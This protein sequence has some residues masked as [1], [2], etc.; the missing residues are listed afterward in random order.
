MSKDELLKSMWRD[1]RWRKKV[2]NSLLTA[3]MGLGDYASMEENKKTLPARGKV[4]PVTSNIIF[5]LR[6]GAKYIYD[7]KELL[8]D[9]LTSN[10]QVYYEIQE[11]RLV[12]IVPARKISAIVDELKNKV[13]REGFGATPPLR[14]L[15]MLR[16]IE[17]LVP[18]NKT[19]ATVREEMEQVLYNF[20]K[21]KTPKPKPASPPEPVKPAPMVQ[22]D[23]S[24]LEMAK[25][26]TTAKRHEEA[27]KY[28]LRAIALGNYPR[29]CINITANTYATLYKQARQSATEEQAEKLRQEAIA[30]MRKHSGELDDTT[31]TWYTLENYYYCMRD[32][33]DFFKV[34]AKLMRQNEVKNDPIKLSDYHNKMAAAYI[35]LKNYSEAKEAINKSLKVMPNNPGAMKLQGVIEELEKLNRALQTADEKEAREIQEKI[36]EISS[37][38]LSSFVEGGLGVFITRL[39]DEYTDME[40]LDAKTKLS[41][42]YTRSTIFNIRGFI[43][44]A[45][46]R[47]D[48][49][50]KL[51]LTEVKVIQALGFQE[52]GISVRG[53]M[54]QYCNTMA[55]LKL[56]NGNDL[57]VV[58]FFYNQAFM[59]G[60]NDR[61][62][63]YTSAYLQTLLYP[64]EE[65][66]RRIVNK[67]S[68][69]VNELLQ[70][71]LL[72]NE[73]SDRNWE[74]VLGLTLYNLVL[75]NQIVMKIYNNADLR[76]CCL[77]MMGHQNLNIDDCTT[78]EAFKSRWDQLR[79]RRL[80]E[81]SRLATQ[82]S[83]FGNDFS[84]LEEIN[85]NLRPELVRWRNES[86]LRNTMDSR[87]LGQILDNVL[88]S[89]SSFLSNRA[90]LIKENAYNNL[91]SQ[92]SKLIADIKENPTKLSYEALI[93]L[94]AKIQSLADNAFDII[95]KTSEPEIKINLLSATVAD[96]GVVSLQ[97]S[98]SNGVDSSPV[99]SVTVIIKNGNGVT[100]IDT[101]QKATVTI[102]GG[103]QHIFK[104][105]VKVSEEVIRKESVSL[106]ITCHY[107]DRKETKPKHVDYS[108]QLPL[109]S[110]EDFKPITNNPYRPGDALAIDDDTF[111]GRELF[112][113]E[114]INDI[115]NRGD[116]QQGYQ[117]IIFGQK[118][119]GKT[120]VWER[121]ASRLQ[122]D[123]YFCVKFS[124]QEILR[125]VTEFT[126][127]YRI[128]KRMDMA[129]NELRS[130]QQE[131]PQF[132]IPRSQSDFNAED[133]EN[134][135]TT[136]IEYMFKFR[137]A[138]EVIPEWRNRKMVLMVD[139]FT[140]I[141]AGVKS[142]RIDPSVMMQWKA[143]TQNRACNFSVILIG[144]DITPTFLNQDYARNAVQIITQKRLTYLSPTEAK[145]LIENPMKKACGGDSPY[146]GEAVDRIIDYTSRNPFYI[147]KVCQSLVSYMNEHKL[148]KVTE[149]D[150][151]DVASNLNWDKNDF[152]NLISGGEY[153]EDV[154]FKQRNAERM[155]L[156]KVI[157][158]LSDTRGYDYC[159]L[160]DILAQINVT[161]RDERD[162]KKALLT[163]LKDRE[164]LDENKE[165]YK[166]QVK[167]FK[168]WLLKQK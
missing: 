146:I 136:F 83:L 75:D 4:S 65:I 120:S 73:Q 151:D 71:A 155:E 147:Q 26:Y 59:L 127:Y 24:A 12:N 113:Q 118:R 63:R 36:E 94:L 133:P 51:F 18:E 162:K 55:Q 159:S 38:D 48:Q 53:E 61:D 103:K 90:Y 143:I 64:A 121:L 17:R 3:I 139:E 145:E 60:Q 161:D 1:L 132:S 76:A 168:L 105:K 112:M 29:S 107:L 154:E 100:F 77:D 69:D 70:Q 102:E 78:Y 165:S 125:S 88:P 124:L 126:F 123:G 134:P 57:D 22:A 106:N 135:A 119:C 96:A 37:S 41:K 91:K 11:G 153:E 25:K 43:E 140:A 128:L 27:L 89:I 52:E 93:P 16:L 8:T 5:D 54:R 10:E 114:I 129:L 149:A 44:S 130:K 46:N 97:V 6:T 34:L 152:D 47:P 50:V 122:Q 104:L 131:V 15:N 101:E 150:I 87:R 148:K 30:F 111:V 116:G 39:L 157:A 81:H 72:G 49:R 163:E 142:G 95:L 19:I 138:C 84:R 79:E 74:E 166:I 9:S 31:K 80:N 7:D 62:E 117:V 68:M 86:W 156:L 141:Y 85:T 14:R 167:L 66:L 2:Y 164:V 99:N 45:K 67:Q 40:G 56:G 144:Q 92:L 33:D 21:E 35:D 137:M 82:I 58:R 32:Y 23:S 42:E 13:A 109:Y 110:S 98:V 108:C 158:R 20:R 28:Y 115:K 160:D